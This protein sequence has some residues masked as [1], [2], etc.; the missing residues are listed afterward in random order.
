MIFFIYVLFGNH[1]VSWIC[2]FMSFTNF[3]KFLAI[4]EMFEFLQTFLL[5]HFSLSFSPGTP[6]TYL[7]DFFCHYPHIL[8]ALF[9]FSIFSLSFSIIKFIDSFLSSLFCYQVYLVVFLLILDIVIFHSRIFI[10]FFKNIF[11]FFAM[12]FKSHL[13]QVH[14][15]LSHWA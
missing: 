5:S 4:E 9:I 6:S 1:R 7:L 2:K 15:P 10:W 14:I 3:E 12:N 8:E 11:Y 13:L